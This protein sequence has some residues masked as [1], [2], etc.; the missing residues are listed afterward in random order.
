MFT[1]PTKIFLR[2]LRALWAENEFFHILIWNLNFA[3]QQFQ[4]KVLQFSPI[5]FVDQSNWD[6]IHPR[7]KFWH[8]IELAMDIFQTPVCVKYTFAWDRAKFRLSQ[9]ECCPI[10]QKSDLK[11]NAS[12]R[13]SAPLWTEIF[14]TFQ[15]FIQSVVHVCNIA[16][17]NIVIEE[18][19]GPLN[20]FSPLFLVA[21]QGNLHLRLT[22]DIPNNHVTKRHWKTFVE[23]FPSKWRCLKWFDYKT[24]TL[25]SWLIVVFSGNFLV[26][27]TSSPIMKDCF[28]MWEVAAGFLYTFVKSADRIECFVPP[29]L[30]LIKVSR[31]LVE[32][33][34]P[35]LFTWSPLGNVFKSQ[36]FGRNTWI[37]ISVNCFQSW[38]AYIKA[39]VC[40]LTLL[41][42]Y[43]VNRTVLC[44]T[45]NVKKVANCSEL[46]FQHPRSITALTGLNQVTCQERKTR[47]FSVLWILMEQSETILLL[48]SQAYHCAHWSQP[49]Y[50]LGKENKIFQ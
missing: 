9:I 21:G 27:S 8:Q 4:T 40:V 17:A 11:S 5:I 24:L 6:C 42:N 48:A 14:L 39:I 15:Y 1:S 12:F 46:C 47:F 44:F 3:F 22:K 2:H 34:W 32:Y 10:F 41:Q 16:G 50:L 7:A 25:V 38:N 23:Y 43:I 36:R 18:M 35:E 30:I 33:H 13:L 26:T 29:F 20:H 37:R 45:E 49:S 31:K 19:I 28:T